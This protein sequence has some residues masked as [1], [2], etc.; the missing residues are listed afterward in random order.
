MGA[1]PESFVGTC[2][3]L[4]DYGFR[5]CVSLLSKN[6]DPHQ[7]VA[8]CLNNI[9]HVLPLLLNPRATSRICVGWELGIDSWL[10]PEQVQ[11]IVDVVAQ[12]NQN[13]DHQ[14]SVADFERAE[15][16]QGRVPDDAIVLQGR[17][18]P[19]TPSV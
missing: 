18:L 6:F 3:E 1:T 12:A 2:R 19:P 13:A 7:D 9:N 5:P 10:L 11:D 4:V 14:V 16:A 17:I 8:G 15:S